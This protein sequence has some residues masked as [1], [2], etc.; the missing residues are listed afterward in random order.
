MTAV[1]PLEI[2]I[3]SDLVNKARVIEEYKKIV[4]SSKDTHRG[5]TSTGHGKYFQPRGQNFKRGGH[6]PQ[7]QGG[8]R[9]NTYNQFQYVK[10]RG[11]QNKISPDL[12]YVRCG[13]FHPYESCKIGIGGCFNCGLPNHIERDCTRGKNPNAGQSQYQGRVFAVN[14]MDA[15]KA[16]PLMRGNCLTGDKILV[17]L[18]DTGASHS[19]ISF[20]KVEELGLKVS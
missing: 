17:A 8:F 4:A 18:Y 20:A 3:F 2:R 14:A 1:A 11:N 6:A 10:G 13:R 12:T 7:S 19:F 9:K 5:N 15:A 16:D